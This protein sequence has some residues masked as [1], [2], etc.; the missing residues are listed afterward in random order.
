[1]CANVNLVLQVK[2]PWKRVTGPHLG[3]DLSI[4]TA[5]AEF[6]FLWYDAPFPELQNTAQEHPKHEVQI[7]KMP[8]KLMQDH[9]SKCLYSQCVAQSFLHSRHTHVHTHRNLV[10]EK[11]KPT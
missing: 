10:K 11:T 3:Q 9:I 1:M 8:C 7:L 6:I 2:C 5:T 4:R